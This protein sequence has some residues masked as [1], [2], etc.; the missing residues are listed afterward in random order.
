MDKY[1]SK[2]IF[3]DDDFMDDLKSRDLAKFGEFN[4]P[5]LDTKIIS[6]SD[7]NCIHEM[8]QS[9]CFEVGQVKHGNVVIRSPC[10]SNYFVSLNDL[11]EDIAVRKYDIFHSFCLALGAKKVSISHV[12]SEFFEELFNCEANAGLSAKVMLGKAAGEIQSSKSKKVSSSFDK[13]V[14]VVSEAEGGEP[15]MVGARKMIEKY[16]LHHDSLFESLYE[17]RSL[18]NNRLLSKEF[19]IDTCKDLQKLIDSSLKAKLDV[20]S[21]FYSVEGGASHTSSD[22][23]K[24]LIAFQL[25]VKVEF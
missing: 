12:E 18:A 9:D 19:L 3:V 21:K 6:L 23:V 24:N 10:R 7:D 8:L 5:P 1:I 25:H 20:V 14:G 2:I 16:G 22:E 15:D 17:S 11:S 13:K 4:N